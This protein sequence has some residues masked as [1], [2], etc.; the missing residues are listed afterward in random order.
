M[1]IFDRIS[2]LFSLLFSSHL[3]LCIV[4]LQGSGKTTLVRTIAQDSFP[5]NT[6]PTIGFNMRPIKVG[7]VN[8]KIW[9]IGYVTTNRRPATIPRYVGALLSRR[10]GNR[11]RGRFERT[12]IEWS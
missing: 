7:S 1:T 9:D 4:G 8:M 2:W 5:E 11:I 6:V 10:F 3:E 12:A